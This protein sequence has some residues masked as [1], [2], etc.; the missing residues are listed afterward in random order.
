M[1][2]PDEESLLPLFFI[3]KY[4][5]L[6]GKNEINWNFFNLFILFFLYNYTY[7]YFK[8]SFLFKTGFK[9]VSLDTLVM[10]NVFIYVCVGEKNLNKWRYCGK[11]FKKE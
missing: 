8:K 5:L 10:G 9:D 11:Y 3:D 7:F 4:L 1:G 2:V 6:W